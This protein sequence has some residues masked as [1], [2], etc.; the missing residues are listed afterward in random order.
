MSSPRNERLH[1]VP[2]VSRED[3]SFPQAVEETAGDE[4]ADTR[5]DDA[6]MPAFAPP[7]AAGDL[8][9]L[10]KYRVQKELGRGGMGAVYLAF[11]ERLQR[12]VALKIMLPRAAANGSAKE[13]FLR[14]ARAAAQIGSDHVVNIFEADEIAGVP[15]I[16]LQY[17]QGYPLDEYLRRKGLPTLP[18]VIR[19]GRETA[20]GLAAAHQLG[21]VHRDI[22]PANLWLEAPTG[23]VKVLDFG[24]A[25]PV[26]GADVTE[27][28]G[29]GAVV[30][31]PSYMA[32]E[33]G[34]GKPVD[35]RADL[36][37]LGCVLYRLCTFRLPFEGPT[38]MAILC[39]LATEEPTP[40]EELNPA[41][42]APL[43]DLIR[44]LLA[45]KPAD[46]PPSAAAVAEEL[47]AMTDGTAEVLPTAVYVPM[48]LTGGSADAG[49]NAFADLTDADSDGDGDSDD[50][51]PPN[52]TRAKPRGSR[53]WL[54][55]GILAAVLMV[56][57]AGAIIIKI[58]NK[59]GTVT[60]I[61]V[62]D[63]AKIE[64]DGKAVPPVP[65]PPV[66]PDPK[67]EPATPGTTLPATFKNEF[68]MEFVRVPKGTAWLG[69]EGG[70]RGDAKVEFRSDFHLGKYEVTQAEWE[71][72]RGKN[73]SHFTR[74]GNGRDEVKGVPD[75][76]L[77]RHPVESV[78][79]DDCR[80][81]VAQLNGKVT[82]PGFVY[83]L[84][85]AAEWEYACRGGPCERPAS[86]FDYYLAE[87]GNA[88][89]TAQ[90]N[91]GV[92]K[93][94]KRTA[95]V[96]SYPPN[97]LGLHDMH[98]N[99]REW[100][101]DAG[102]S[103]D[104]IPHK[105]HRG[106]GWFNDAVYCRAVS[107]DSSPATLR[108]NGIGLR[109]ARVPA[110]GAA[111]DPDRA[112]VE[113]LFARGAEFSYSAATGYR[114]VAYGKKA[115]LPAGAIALH[116]F[117]LSK[118]EFAADADLERFRGLRT[119][120]TVVLVET[121]FSDAG[122]ESL[123]AIPN[124]RKLYLS[125]TKIT[126]DGLRR[127][128]KVPSLV[129]LQ[130]G[131]T[132]VT[133][134]GLEHLVGLGALRQ[135][136]LYNTGVT[137][138]GVKKLA[139]TLPDCKVEWNGG[140]IDPF[141]ADPDRAAA[142]WVLSIGGLVRVNGR[143]EGVKAAADLPREAIRLTGVFLDG[144]KQVTD[145]GLAAFKDCKGL[146]YLG[147]H[148]TP[149]TDAG[150]AAFKDCKGLTHLGLYNT[151]VTDEG[152]AAFK[153]CKGLTVLG[154]GGTQVTDAGLAA[155]KDCKGL[156]LLNLGGTPVTD[157]GL[158]AFKDCKGLTHLYLE[159]T[160]VTDAG[161]AAFKEL[162]G[163]TYLDVRKTG[164]TAKGATD[165][166]AVVPGCKVEH[167]GGVIEPKAAA[168]PERG[169]A[170]YVLSIGGM[171]RVNGAASDI[172]TAAELPKERFTLTGVNLNNNTKVTD[173]GLAA[174]KDCKGLT[175]LVLNGTPVTDAGLAVFKDC[176]GL[177]FL[178][179]RAMKVTDA[180][181]TAFKDCKGLTGLYLNDTQV[182]DAGLA[183][184]RDCKGL[185]IL[186]V[187]QTGVTA[188]GATDF[189]AAVPG[190][191]VEHDGGV[192]EPKK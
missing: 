82:E 26:V 122:C 89:T 107:R 133:D 112:A 174:F 76:D 93:T 160:K 191:K 53:S 12:R 58:T 134:A 117:K 55:G 186:E 119:L 162:K 116:S 132:K 29:S 46:R 30:G 108:L 94:L 106:G 130:L 175:H 147:L 109:L 8:G 188:K 67:V 102:R 88:V 144:N 179:L 78:S 123:S 115:D 158:A 113:W 168:D 120:D 176:K 84:P 189:H 183:P 65:K 40:V 90:A 96:G 182:T 72:V 13:R 95:R 146:T 128:G 63:G 49:P 185:T 156:T 98:G 85:T 70:N 170:T 75:A 5:P 87:P 7:T 118:K 100:C 105:V 73:P 50:L 23:R 138:A 11:D 97:A 142:E 9:R 19:I 129:V 22:K 184:F 131:G 80:A 42:P 150:L 59:D 127:L 86:G 125:D 24:L 33:Q 37:S 165:F 124:L 71:A 126:N 38:V 17:L 32:P 47:A 153:D 187:R 152:L 48:P 145:A 36:F 51:P 177:T 10:G 21:F 18:Q 57:A 15:Y 3:D 6:A 154:L 178:D 121:G 92:A 60:E 114:S 69:G 1:D 62:P 54:I 181:L 143:D 28:T 66:P 136:L 34:M 44:R 161:L 103:D 52:A 190:C 149:V 164:V 139:A 155:F 64:V 43:A 83:R 77:P 35:G 173:A 157:A 166:H 169:A 4:P 172:R 111:A 110:G 20:L 31:T 99:V 81:F 148:G 141:A 167:D 14:E 79:W 68:G 171:V 140:V 41:V 101:D 163:L 135:V 151:Q 39:A 104:G 180:G 45:K 192:I 74:T 91:V 61:K 25:K 16:A 137:D 159:G 2:T 27:L 56:V